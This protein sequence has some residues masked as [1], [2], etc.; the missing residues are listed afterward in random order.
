MSEEQKMTIVLKESDIEFADGQLIYE[1]VI[2]YFKALPTIQ[3]ADGKKVTPVEL[4][5]YEYQEAKM[6]KGGTVL[7]VPAFSGT[8]DKKETFVLFPCKWNEAYSCFRIPKKGE[9]LTDAVWAYDMLGKDGKK[10]NKTRTCSKDYDDCNQFVADEFRGRL[11]EKDD[12]DE[13][14]R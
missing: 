14:Q 10:L 2:D 4:K 8:N 13:V 3:K 12:S 9:K 7:N 5:S 1:E 6:V 11:E